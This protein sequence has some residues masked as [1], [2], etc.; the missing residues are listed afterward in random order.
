[1]PY[2]KYFY[3]IIVGDPGIVKEP[4]NSEMLMEASS[5]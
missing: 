1:M 2:G 3:K 5:L 4:Y